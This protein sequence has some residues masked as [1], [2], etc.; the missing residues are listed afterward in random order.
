VLAACAAVFGVVYVAAVLLLGVIKPGERDALRRHFEAL[1][2]FA[3]WR[4]VP[5]PTV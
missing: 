1:Q 5:D 3:P 2:R 4:R